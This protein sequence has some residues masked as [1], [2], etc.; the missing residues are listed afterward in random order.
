MSRS[1]SGFALT[2]REIMAIFLAMNATIA[3]V[4]DRF[5]ELVDK[6]QAGETVVITRH[7]RPVARLTQ[8][9]P[10]GKPRVAAKPLDWQTFR[11]IDL[12]E[13][14]FDSWDK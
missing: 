6:V 2:I 11:D 5:C 13:P 9:V 7:G 12:D 8:L 4:K 1:S 10:E 14:S 3:E